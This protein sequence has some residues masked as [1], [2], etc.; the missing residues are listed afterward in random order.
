MPSFFRF[1]FLLASAGAVGS[2]VYV[3]KNL[4]KDDEVRKVT[5]GDIPKKPKMIKS[6]I[7][8]YDGIIVDSETIFYQ[9]FFNYL[10]MGWLISGGNMPQVLSANY[11]LVPPLY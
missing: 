8:D 4:Y 3:A 1:P 10:K 6:V 11:V 2:A 5:G 7:F 9:V